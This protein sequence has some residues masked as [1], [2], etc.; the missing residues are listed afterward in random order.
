MRLEA[1]AS[2]GFEE[3]AETVKLAAA[4]STS[5]TVKLIGPV[6]E[7]SFMLRSAILEM[8]GRSFTAR[9]VTVKFW[10]TT[11]FWAW[12]SFTLTVMMAVPFALGSGAQLKNPAG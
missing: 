2:V 4:V 3:D 1:G 12:P 7:S 6:D 11:L 10:L 5:E 9:T 8:S